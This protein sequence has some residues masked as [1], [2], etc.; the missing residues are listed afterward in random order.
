MTED[1]NLNENMHIFLLMKLAS[2]KAKY[3]LGLRK[4]DMK[5]I[6]AQ[7]PNAINQIFDNLVEEI[8]QQI[9]IIEKDSVVMP[10]MSDS[11]N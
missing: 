4:K 7:L 11:I 8:K 1:L 5:E 9:V 2:I 6:V 3:D 10:K